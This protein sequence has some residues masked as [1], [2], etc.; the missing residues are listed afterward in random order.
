M[1]ELFD[2]DNVV[3]ICDETGR[4][5]SMVHLATVQYGTKVYFVL[6]AVRETEEGEE[7][8][9]LL[10]VREETTVDG[11]QEYV[12]ANDAEEVENV[13]RHFFAQSVMEALGMDAQEDEE[14]PEVC[15]VCGD[16]HGPGEFCFCG[17][18]EFLQ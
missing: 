12:V 2:D 13:V 17:Q 4:K 15:P 6:G 11:E 18:P 3:E 5:A 1:T 16:T 8:R 9:G 10:L 14:E 7:E